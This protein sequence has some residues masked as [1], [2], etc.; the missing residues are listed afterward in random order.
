[1]KLSPPASSSDLE[2]A[3]AIAR[4]LHRQARGPE[5]S[6]LTPEGPPV[7]ASAPPAPVPPRRPTAAFERPAPPSP[8]PRVPKGALDGM[9]D[10]GV[11][12]LAT[13]LGGLSAETD[14][15]LQV[16]PEDL[17]SDVLPTPSG[18]SPEDLVGGL[19]AEPDL[20]A[21]GSGEQGL[22]ELPAVDVGTSEEES[23]DALDTCVRISSAQ[24]AMLIDAQGRVFSSRGDWPEPG[25]EAVAAK[26]V[27]AMNRALTGSPT[28][29]VSVP[30]GGLHLTAWRVPTSAGLI[31]I[32]FVA[33]APLRSDVRPAIDEE[34]RRSVS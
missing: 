22:G 26:L 10:V 28:R 19:G 9:V 32:A 34:V 18:V 3:R 20:S 24:G 27:P 13:P 29:S 7:P 31:T 1:M 21:G 5:S 12:D 33:E 25:A 23:V 16:G 2:T 11:G 6:P 14:P 17:V 30:V 8:P 15:G 4:R